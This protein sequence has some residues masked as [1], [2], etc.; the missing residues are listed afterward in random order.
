M[1]LLTSTTTF[2]ME[3]TADARKIQ[4]GVY[5]NKPGVFLD[6][7]GSVKGFYIDILDY[8]A[9][10]ENWNISYIFGSWPQGLENLKNGKIDLLVAIAYTSEREEIFDFN[11]ETALANWGQVYVRND[12][13]HSLIDLG[14]K[15][16][17]GLEKDIYTISL[18]KLLKSLD[19]PHTFIEVPQYGDAMKLVAAGKANAA[20]VSRTNGLTLEME[21]PL[22]RSP[23]ICC[24]VEIRYAVAKGKNHDLLAGLD[25][26]L[27]L[28]KEDK[29]SV[30]YK[31]MDHWFGLIRPQERLPTWLWWTFAVVV[32]LLILF[33]GGNLLLRKEVAQRT[34][35][36]LAA[37]E[38]AEEA[39]KVKSEF[40]ANMSHEIR[41]PLNAVIG[42]TDLVLEMPLE[43]EQK[44]YL[45]IVL[46]SAESL[47]AILNSILDLSKIEA[48]RM[49]LESIM[50]PLK[51]PVGSTCDTMAV[52]AH[53]KDLELYLDVDVSVPEMIRGDPFRLRQILINLVNNAVK[54]TKQGEITLRVTS[55]PVVN[56]NQE[57]VTFSVTD[58]GI[59]IPAEKREK[60]FDSFTQAD[61]STSRNYGGTGLGLTISRQLVELMGGHLEL[62]SEVGKGSRF[63]FTLTVETAINPLERFNRT[64]LQG[65]K[66][67]VADVLATNRQIVTQILTRLG[68][69]VTTASNGND[70]WKQL[71]GETGTDGQ[72][73]KPV[74]PF[75]ALIIGHKIW[76]GADGS[77]FDKKLERHPDLCKTTVAMLP[78]HRRKNDPHLERG[79]D[80]G[81]ILVKP[82]HPERLLQTLRSLP[83][84]KPVAASPGTID[85]KKTAAVKDKG[86]SF[87]VLVVEDVVNNQQLVTDVLNRAGHT[88]SLAADG[89]TALKL[90]HREVFDLVLM[91]LML[92]GMDGYAVTREIR[93]QPPNKP[94][95]PAGVPIVGITAHVLK[96]DQNKCIEAGMDGFLAKP[97]RPRDL[98][99]VFYRLDKQLT[100][101]KAVR[102]RASAVTILRLDA[103]GSPQYLATRRTVFLPWSQTM[104]H[105]LRAVESEDFLSTAAHADEL[106]QSAN[107]V[108]ADLVRNESFKLLIATRN[109]NAAEQ[110]RE[111][112]RELE[113]EYLKAVM[114]MVIA[115]SERLGN[116]EG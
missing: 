17:A 73:A 11:K 64:P 89:P 88:W 63:Y 70:V 51:D 103:I 91:D 54:F 16:V 74:V 52:N 108:G 45:E 115:E 10:Q 48:R 38:T 15:T 78:A 100:Q 76:N 57:R 28:I 72:I 59:G 107:L 50:F 75:A 69:E 30:Y 58:T 9:L 71:V 109:T 6:S 3:F 97:F 23:I 56:T 98:L 82:A 53:R 105:L 94:G 87:H 67:L 35:E 46:N 112:F 104:T 1:V 79:P 49:E 83:S 29:R 66:L 101:K 27:T 102:T 12:A 65:L 14:N 77:E 31:S 80:V 85:H 110:I 7:S 68:A 90:I 13:I 111:R 25:H 21:Y 84:L 32:V 86:N 5:E 41:T 18:Q 19:I 4:V 114:V 96:G 93:N 47:L 95:T 44:S 39:S 106:K 62:E 116:T 36:L 40:L 37:K 99:S 81:A 60:I 22:I 113:R 92:P 33:I 42:M 2:A 43:R 20:I 34:K 26:H 8:V 55:V 61:G 24:P